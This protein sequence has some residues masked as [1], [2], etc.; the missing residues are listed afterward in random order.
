MSCRLLYASGCLE[1]QVMKGSVISLVRAVSMNT[2]QLTGNRSDSGWANDP[3]ICWGLF[4][5]KADR[6]KGSGDYP[7]K[8]QMV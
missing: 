3:S 2:K 5:R 7:A 6:S 4:S 1:R 8:L